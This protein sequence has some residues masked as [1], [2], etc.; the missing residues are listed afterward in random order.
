PS[1]LVIQILQ[2]AFAMG[3][4]YVLHKLCLRI[5]RDKQNAKLAGL[6]APALW[7]ASPVVLPHTMNCLETGLYTLL[8]TGAIYEYSVDRSKL[9]V[10]R[11]AL[12]G[13]M[14]SFTFLARMDASSF[15]GALWL[16]HLI[17]VQGGGAFGK[18]LSQ[19]VLMG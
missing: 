14:R 1:V 2:V 10:G 5:V 8:L 3:T 17:V 12:F 7:F 19:T 18:R 15:V 13:V 4:A 9:S 6:L 16:I 11:F